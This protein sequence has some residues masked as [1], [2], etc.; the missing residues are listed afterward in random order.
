MCTT[1]S[2]HGSP[3]FGAVMPVYSKDG[4]D[5]QH[6]LKQNCLDGQIMSVEKHICHVFH[7]GFYISVTV[8]IKQTRRKGLVELHRCWESFHRR[9]LCFSMFPESILY[10]T[11]ICLCIIRPTVLSVFKLKL[12]ALSCCI[13]LVR[14]RLLTQQIAFWLF[15]FF[16]YGSTVSL[17]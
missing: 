16:F 12:R 5:W 14:I 13:S 7:N 9:A 4:Y 11:K 17:G 10:P 15:K 6:V 2:V 8:W 3:R 1:V